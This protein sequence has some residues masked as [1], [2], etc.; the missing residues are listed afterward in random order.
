MQSAQYT[1]NSLNTLLQGDDNIIRC[2]DKL[3]FFN[4]KAELWHT[5]VENGIFL[6]MFPTLHQFIENTNK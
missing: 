3:E 2:N 5:E 1:L 6:H 4:R